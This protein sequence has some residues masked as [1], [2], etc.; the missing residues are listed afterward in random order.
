MKSESSFRTSFSQTGN[1]I[2]IAIVHGHEQARTP[3]S[4]L[5]LLDEAARTCDFIAHSTLGADLPAGSPFYA[6]LLAPEYFFVGMVDPRRPMTEAK[7]DNVEAALFAISRAH[8]KV[9]IIPGTLFYEK[10]R[11]RPAEHKFKLLARGENAGQRR[12][13][14]KTT[15]RSDVFLRKINHAIQT[16]ETSGI[17]SLQRMVNRGVE[18]GP[19][20]YAPSMRRKEE[21]LK[22]KARG[23]CRN[24]TYIFL[25]GERLAKYDKCFDY[26]ESH[27]PDDLV[28][29]HGSVDQTTQVGE[30]KFGIEIC[31]DHELKILATRKVT[32]DFQ[33]VVSD[34]VDTLEESMSLRS[35]GYYLHASTRWQN[36]SIWQRD[37][38][39]DRLVNH[40]E[41][42]H[43][44]RDPQGGVRQWYYIVDLPNHFGAAAAAA[45]SPPAKDKD[46]IRH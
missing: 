45:A 10:S 32:V 24:R 26:F 4:C 28:F 12:G 34:Y 40:T 30:Y 5:Q 25:G 7:K 17:E 31:A 1:K 3:D 20:L 46:R 42:F 15:E 39:S 14:E 21:R 35:G 18:D 6:V 16:A 37:P 19:M 38:V 36:S 13:P 11:Q 2:V 27:Q 29:L 9:L 22:T 41:H 43:R 8:P 44:R 33:V 23:I